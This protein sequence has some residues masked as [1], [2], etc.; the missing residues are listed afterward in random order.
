MGTIMLEFKRPSLPREVTVSYKTAIFGTIC[1]SR[2]ADENMKKSFLPFM[3][4]VSI[5]YPKFMESARGYVH[6]S[7]NSHLV[8]L[9]SYFFSW[10]IACTGCHRARFAVL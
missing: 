5:C 10:N 6:L 4:Q 1:V 7:G 3:A 9:G 2:K 8:L